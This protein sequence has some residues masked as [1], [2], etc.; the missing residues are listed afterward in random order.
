D[1]QGAGAEGQLVRLRVADGADTAGNHDGLVVAALH[2]RYLLLV[3]AEV[4]A[5]IGAAELVVE[6]GATEWPVDHDLQRAGDVLGLAIL[7]ALPRLARSRQVEVAHR[8]AG[9]ACLGLRAAA[10]GTLIADLAAG[11]GG[12]TRMR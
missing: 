11:A 8:E 1:Q 5:E 6:G 3:D 10:G 4:A 9:Q 7:N 12:G 2:A